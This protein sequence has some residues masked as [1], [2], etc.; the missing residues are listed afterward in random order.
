MIN[1]RVRGIAVWPGFLPAGLSAYGA[2]FPMDP[3]IRPAPSSNW[4]TALYSKEGDKMA[5]REFPYITFRIFPTI[6][7]NGYAVTSQAR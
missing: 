4:G 2:K 7:N 3:V 5:V 6:S 1:H